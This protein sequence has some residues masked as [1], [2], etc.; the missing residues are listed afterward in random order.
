MSEFTF[1]ENNH[2]EN[3]NG[4]ILVIK[5]EDLKDLKFNEIRDGYGNLVEWEFSGTDEEQS[6]QGEEDYGK[7]IEFWD[8]SNWK[9]IVFESQYAPDYRYS[10]IEDENQIAELTKAIETK[11]FDNDR[12]TGYVVYIGG[13][14]KIIKSSWQGDWELFTMS[15]KDED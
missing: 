14:Y 2:T 9:T 5:T 8:G 11:E 1:I 6:E 15:E 12:Q 13:D 10:I 7:G 3:P 4:E